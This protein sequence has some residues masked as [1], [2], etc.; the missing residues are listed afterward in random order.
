MLLRIRS[1]DGLERVNVDENGNV[2]TLMRAIEQ[3]LRVPISDQGLSTNQGILLSKSPDDFRNMRDPSVTLRSLG[4]V[5]GSL[6]FLKY[7]GERT[8][9]GP[10][11]R[12]VPAGSFGRKMTMDDLIAKQTRIERQETPHCKLLSFDRDAANSFQHYV[13]ET[14]AFAVKRG[15]F[16]Y[17]SSNEAGEVM[18]DFIYEPPQQGLEDNILLLR[19]PEEE[20]V[21][22]TIA[23]ALGMRKVG[24]IFTQTVGA[25]SDDFTLTGSEVR[26]AAELQTE[27]A[28]PLRGPATSADESATG[29][30]G[31]V[32]ATD[33][34][35]EASTASTA[36]SFP[37]F[38]IA[39]VK[40]E[41]NEEGAADVHFE[42]FQLSDQCLRLFQEGWF[43]DGE[44]RPGA[45]GAE[46]GKVQ[47]G[48]AV[49]PKLSKMKKE[50]I[51]AGKDTTMVDNDFFLVPVK[52]SDHEGL[53][54]STFPVEN[55]MVSPTQQSLRSHLERNRTKSYGQ[56]LADFHLLFFLSRFLDPSSDIPI[57][58][59]AVR[60]K[61]SIPD[62][63]QLI[64]ESL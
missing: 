11:C 50:V 60:T 17:G 58:A 22:D 29:R 18:V 33:A 64:I 15:G 38:S 44:D 32:A 4:L 34:D 25:Q 3:D 30:N 12:V 19:N 62:G 51:V 41:V 7:S 1:R 36:S 26:L 56:R 49:E 10:P 28:G 39:V 59:E 54:T 31:K 6:V 45:D 13:N 24:F 9:Q 14:L 47:R 57:L 20:K 40:L 42:A 27:F 55:R 8:V 35:P 43:A 46:S 2:E 53:L 21:V 61:S 52:I 63:Y 37:E 16:M 48:E 23:S 5:H